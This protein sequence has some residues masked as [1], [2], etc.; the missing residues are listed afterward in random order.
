MAEKWVLA[1]AIEE[2]EGRIETLNQRGNRLYPHP[3]VR[4]SD[5]YLSDARPLLLYMQR[6][7]VKRLQDDGD[8]LVIDYVFGR[9]DPQAGQPTLA[10]SL[11][12]YIY[13]DPRFTKDRR[14][15]DVIVP[16][17]SAPTRAA[18]EVVRSMSPHGWPLRV[19][20]VFTVVS[21]PEHEPQ[22]DP[23]VDPGTH[24][25]DGITGVSRKLIQ[26]AREA[27]ERFRLLLG[28]NDE[29][30]WFYKA[31]LHQANAAHNFLIGFSPSPGSGPP[32]P[33]ADTKP[34]EFRGRIGKHEILL[35]IR[36]R[37][38]LPPND[39][40]GRTRTG[41]LLIPDELMV[42]IASDVIKAAYEKKVPTFVQQLEWVCPGEWNPEGPYALAG[43]GVS[44]EWIGRKAGERVYEV[45]RDKRK[46]SELPVL[47]PENDPSALEFWIN[48]DVANDLAIPIPDDARRKAKLCRRRASA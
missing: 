39:P 29:I 2:D 34:H 13:R 41:L 32:P 31:D 42:S 3:D 18:R 27:L 6:T 1:A 14:L 43:Y 30:H 23:L 35:N 36:D 40:Q 22:N 24:R 5:K 45:L 7:L 44:P 37:E 28:D 46:A 12:D 16:I 20:I 9:R 38:V 48:E 26:T 47:S 10:D 19:P 33:P 25:G 4:I 11:R 15:P 17:A 8:A 21:D